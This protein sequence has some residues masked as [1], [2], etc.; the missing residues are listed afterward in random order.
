[1]AI[2]IYHPVSYTFPQYPPFLFFCGSYTLLVILGYTSI[3]NTVLVILHSPHHG[4]KC[5]AHCNL[6]LIFLD[7]LFPSCS[8]IRWQ[9]VVRIVSLQRKIKRYLQFKTKLES[10]LSQGGIPLR[11]RTEVGM[12]EEAG[13]EMAAFHWIST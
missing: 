9:K 12:S 2:P 5:F 6:T 1:M 11:R 7:N 8:N 3:S 4:Q 13:E 10:S